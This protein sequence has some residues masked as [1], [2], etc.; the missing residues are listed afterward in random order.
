MFFIMSILTAF[1]EQ[2]FMTS[3]CWAHTFY[4]NVS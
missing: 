4:S 3:S 2:N 1:I